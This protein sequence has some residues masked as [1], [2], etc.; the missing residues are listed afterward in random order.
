MNYERT[1]PCLSI[2]RPTSFIIQVT[3]NWVGDCVGGKGYPNIEIND[4][5]PYVNKLCSGTHLIAR[6]ELWTTMSG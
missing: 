3:A 6:P 1:A 2:E 4:R 5:Q